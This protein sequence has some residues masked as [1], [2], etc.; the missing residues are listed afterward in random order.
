MKPKQCGFCDKYK[1]A[2]KRPKTTP[3]VGMCTPRKGDQCKITNFNQ[4]CK[5]WV[6]KIGEKLEKQSLYKTKPKN[7]SREG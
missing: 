4:T 3:L 2:Y 1:G 5:Y 7:K 6:P